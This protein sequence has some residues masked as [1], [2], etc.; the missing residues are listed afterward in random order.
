MTWSDESSTIWPKVNCW[1]ASPGGGQVNHDFR[2]RLM[3]RPGITPILLLGEGVFHQFHGGV[4]T[5]VPMAQHPRELFFSEHE[6]IRGHRYTPAP[7]PEVVYFGTLPRPA[8]RF[9]GPCR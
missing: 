1:C 7:T 9:L 4:A 5:N 6:R 3:T 2:N 8:R